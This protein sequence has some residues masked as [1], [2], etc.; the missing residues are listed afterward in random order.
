MSGAD[1][2]IARAVCGYQPL[3]KSCLVLNG[4]VIECSIILSQTA[5]FLRKGQPGSAGSFLAD[6]LKHLPVCRR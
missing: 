4:L 2:H 1:E 6:V 5:D 3:Q